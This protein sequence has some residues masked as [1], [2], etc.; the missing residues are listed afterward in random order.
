MGQLNIMGVTLDALPAHLRE[1]IE[2]FGFRQ[3][4]SLINMFFCRMMC[5]YSYLNQLLTTP[6]SELKDL[7]Q[8]FDELVRVDFLF[9]DILSLK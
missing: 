7:L 6:R 9:A 5:P 2:F 8:N 1:R 3:M 4:V